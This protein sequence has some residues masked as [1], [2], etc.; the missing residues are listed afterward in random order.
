VNLYFREEIMKMEKLE[1]P[2]EFRC[3]KC[4]KSH[5]AW[6]VTGDTSIR[7][8]KCFECIRTEEMRERED[9]EIA[10]YNAEKERTA[11]RCTSCGSK[12]WNNATLCTPCCD[13]EVFGH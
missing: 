3:S 10:E 7:V 8:E 1:I 9:K 11:R 13:R 5:V 4:K 6:M 12:H 2:V